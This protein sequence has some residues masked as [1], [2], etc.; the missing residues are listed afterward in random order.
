LKT[1]SIIM[2]V[3]LT[4]STG[5]IG[6]EVIEQCIKNPSITSIVALS[7]RQ[8][9]ESLTASPKVQVVIVDDYISYTPATLQAIQGADACIWCVFLSLNLGLWPK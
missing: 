4:G 3:I 6:R 7:R 8:L 9:P 2:K 1:N 5:F